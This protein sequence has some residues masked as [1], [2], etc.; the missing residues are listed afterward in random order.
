MR[1]LI[2]GFALPLALAACSPTVREYGSGGSGPASGT[3]SAAS[4]GST[5]GSGGTGGTGGGTPAKC[6][7]SGGVFKVLTDT[8]F[9][10]GGQLDDKPILVAD[11]GPAG[12]NKPSVHVL[13]SNRATGTMY[14]R[15]IIDDPN[16]VG[17]LVKYGG[18]AG[19]SFQFAGG[20]VDPGKLLHVVGSLG[21]TGI[22]VMPIPVDPYKGV[23][24]PGS[25][26][27][28]PTPMACQSPNRVDRLQVVHDG[29]GV[30]Y[31][32]SCVLGTTTNASLWVG[33]S[34][35]SILFQVATGMQ[36]D[37]AMRPS[38]YAWQNGIHLIGV[39]QDM[40]TG[41]FFFGPD[42]ALGATP[43]PF[44]IDPNQSSI[45]MGATPLPDGSGV[46][47]FAASI[48]PNLT[49]GSIWGGSV[50]ALDYSKLGEVPP[51]VLGKYFSFTDVS[52]AAGFTS[53][54]FDE[55]H[56]VTAGS[57]LTKDAV[58]FDLLKRDGTPLVIEQQVY[59]AMGTT[60]L[61]AVAAPLGLQSVV[62][63]IEQ[64]GANPP[65]YVVQGQLMVCTGG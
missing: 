61:T 25:L 56:V 37:L 14:V 20:W 16:P 39:S 43:V 55:N 52:K 54:T 49:S 27:A 18:P 3:S 1:R 9:G 21:N 57:S 46:A 10:V 23:G 44:T 13:V 4:S 34:D 24:S 11:P 42:G 35:P 38:L 8:D 26:S 64:D 6:T 41:G 30:R 50:Q 17:N 29:T 63:W 12:M 53:P 40:G 59:A 45:L 32:V 28:V 58:Y 36:N 31:A 7:P 51:P 5:G 48:D 62:I 65:N 33:G 2:P 22:S 19:P 60:I 47:L 15:S